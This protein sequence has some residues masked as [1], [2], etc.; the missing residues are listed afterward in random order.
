VLSIRGLWSAVW[1]ALPLLGIG[2]LIF[3]TATDDLRG[4]V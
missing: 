2:G 4:S 3:R 1:P